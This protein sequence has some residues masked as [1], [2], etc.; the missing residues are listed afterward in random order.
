VWVWVSQIK[1][2]T[3]WE[4]IER[5]RIQDV[6]WD[7]CSNTFSSIVQVSLDIHEESLVSILHLCSV[8]MCVCCVCM[9]RIKNSPQRERGRVTNKSI[10]QTTQFCVCVRISEKREMCVLE[11]NWFLSQQRET[12]FALQHQSHFCLCEVHIVQQSHILIIIIMYQYQHKHKNKWK[13]CEW[14]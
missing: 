9:S 13:L 14:M 7:L 4:G 10:K 2:N 12:W 6:D 1:T 3:I 8:Y 5:E 11:W